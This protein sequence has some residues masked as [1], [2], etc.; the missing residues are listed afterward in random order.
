MQKLK[1][2]VMH[3]MPETNKKKSLNDFCLTNRIIS[4]EKTN[5]MKINTVYI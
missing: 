5:A 2:M 3:K 4:N 1:M